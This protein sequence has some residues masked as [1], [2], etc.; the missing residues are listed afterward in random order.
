MGTGAPQIIALLLLARLSQHKLVPTPLHLC[1]RSHAEKAR[2][3]GL[4][5]LQT[6]L[7]FLVL[8]LHPV[9]SHSPSLSLSSLICKVG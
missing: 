3:H 6:Q 1:P 4:R 2:W 5:G 8:P 7:S 9:A